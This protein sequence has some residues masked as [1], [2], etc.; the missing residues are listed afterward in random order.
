M[1]R[2]PHCLEVYRKLQVTWLSAAATSAP[3]DSS[4]CTESVS[5][6]FEASMSGVTPYTYVCNSWSDCR[7]SLLGLVFCCHTEWCYSLRVFQSHIIVV[8]RLLYCYWSCDRSSHK[9]SSLLS[10]QNCAGEAEWKHKRQSQQPP[11]FTLYRLKHLHV[12]G[13]ST[14]NQSCMHYTSTAPSVAA[15]TDWWQ[16]RACVVVCSNNHNRRKI[17]PTTTITIRRLTS[18]KD[19]SIT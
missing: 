12:R 11:A 18:L 5:E 19:S 16:G 6:A 1:P 17:T 9:C 10:T 2:G 13:T 7:L 4:S 15:L 14:S 8:I 3:L